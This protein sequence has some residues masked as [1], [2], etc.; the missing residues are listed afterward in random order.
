MI[1]R[2][3]KPIADAFSKMSEGESTNFVRSLPPVLLVDRSTIPTSTDLTSCYI[4]CRSDPV[5]LIELEI[6]TWR[7]LPW[8][9]VHS[10][11]DLL[12]IR[13][14]QLQHR[15]ENL[16]EATLHLQCMRLEEKERHDL[17]HSILQEKLAIGSTVLLYDTRREKDMS[18]KLSFKWLG[19][20]R[21]AMQ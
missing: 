20:Y 13:A 4:R 16:E 8:D 2:G 7:I 12:A 10:T 19:S 17:K 21:T 6:S 1:E 9:I 3:N 15:D 11:A 14:R 18:L 5:L